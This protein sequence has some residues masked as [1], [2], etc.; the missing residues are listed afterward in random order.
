MFDI[1]SSGGG[2]FFGG[3]QCAFFR[4]LEALA[5]NA[6]HELGP[7]SYTHLDVYKRQRLYCKG[8][9][10]G[11]SAFSARVTDRAKAKDILFRLKELFPHEAYFPA[12]NA[13]EIQ[14]AWFP[15]PYED[16]GRPPR[17]QGPPSARPQD[18]QRL[19]RG[20][21]AEDRP[22]QARTLR[23]PRRFRLGKSRN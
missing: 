12:Q 1:M 16:Q 23:F 17:P 11:M 2:E 6:A 20:V 9:M 15:C 8:C 4:E 18:A 10:L 7:V 14:G 5:R 21:A 19:I 13:P 3:N 22:A